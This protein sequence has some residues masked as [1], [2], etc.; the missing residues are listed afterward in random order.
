MHIDPEDMT[1]PEADAAAVLNK[2]LAGIQWFLV[3]GI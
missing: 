2:L 3:C 1:G